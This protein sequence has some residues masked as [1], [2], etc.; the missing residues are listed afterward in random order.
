MPEITSSVAADQPIPLSSPHFNL[1]RRSSASLLEEL[2][3]GEAL[4]HQKIN[5]NISFN[6]IFP[7]CAVSAATTEECAELKNSMRGLFG[8]LTPQISMAAVTQQGVPAAGGCAESAAHDTRTLHHQEATSSCCKN[9]SR[10]P[11]SSCARNCLTTSNNAGVTIKTEPRENCYSNT[12]QSCRNGT[13]AAAATI[14]G[15]GGL[16]VECSMTVKQEAPYGRPCT[17]PVHVRNGN[18]GNSMPGA[19][20]TNQYKFSFSCLPSNPLPHHHNTGATTLGGEQ[21]FHPTHHHHNQS[22]G[23]GGG[24]FFHQQQQDYWQM[25]PTPPN[26]QPASPADLP[27]GAPPHPQPYRVGITS[28]LSQ[29][30][31]PPPPYEMA[32]AANVAPPLTAKQQ[33]AETIRYN[34]KNNPDLERRRV[35]F[36]HYPGKFE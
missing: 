30:R 29:L 36:C 28:A 10:T 33:Q 7:S 25:P 34:R 4:H 13:A 32:V 17:L 18:A 8:N 1:D 20:A 27:V 31:G 19:A 3:Q 9:M 14:F 2:L 5:G 26:S 35:H 11:S 21:M 24:T 6:A 12:M 16:S 23:P 22:G 15:G